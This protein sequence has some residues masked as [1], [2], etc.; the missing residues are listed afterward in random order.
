MAG[1]PLQ[2]VLV[3][4][5]TDS[6]FV[7][8]KLKIKVVLSFHNVPAVSSCNHIVHTAVSPTFIPATFYTPRTP[9][10]LRAQEGQGLTARDQ[11]CVPELGTLFKSA[12][13][14]MALAW[15][16]LP[17]G[18]HHKISRLCFPLFLPPVELGMA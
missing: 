12:N 9:F 11:L 13:P 3:D 10:P 4:L 14:K 7:K 8:A 2:S 6:G 15:P 16:C 17:H 18:K 5:S 1:A